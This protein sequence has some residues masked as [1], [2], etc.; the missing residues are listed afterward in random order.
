MNFA[1]FFRA[2]RQSVSLVIVID[3]SSCDYQTYGN[4]VEYKTKKSLLT[5]TKT[6]GHVIVSPYFGL[7]YYSW[8]TRG[9]IGKEFSGRWV[10]NSS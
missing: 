8:S 1:S 7:S 9:L 3:Y 10:F 6:V 5:V 2:R 4:V